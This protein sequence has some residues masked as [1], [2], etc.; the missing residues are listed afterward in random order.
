MLPD[1]ADKIA[2]D[3]EI[4]PFE[5]VADHAGN[6]DLAPVY[7]LQRAYSPW[8]P[9][10]S[11]RQPA[12]IACFHG[13]SLG[14][15]SGNGKPRGGGGKNRRRCDTPEGNAPAELASR[16]LRG[17]LQHRLLGCLQHRGGFLG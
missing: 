7:G 13:V 17:V 6:N 5:R 1:R 4:V 12:M 14:W 8:P 15:R 16:L 11:A 9:P 3:R 2:V 10:G